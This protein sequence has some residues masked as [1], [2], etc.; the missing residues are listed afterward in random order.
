MRGCGD[1]VATTCAMCDGV[2]GGA[3]VGGVNVTTCAVVGVGGDVAGI[4]GIECIGV[5]GANVWC[6]R[7]W[8]VWCCLR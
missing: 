5:V 1:V 6:C 7:C 2:V 8:Y 3:D 4:T